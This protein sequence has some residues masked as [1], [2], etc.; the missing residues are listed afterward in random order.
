MQE[1]R[2]WVKVSIHSQAFAEAQ[3]AELHVEVP[4]NYGGNFPLY[5]TKVSLRAGKCQLFL[6]LSFPTC[7]VSE[8][9]LLRGLASTSFASILTSCHSPVRRLK[10]GLYCQ[11]TQAWQLRAPLLWIQILA[12]WW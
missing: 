7:K 10:V 12:S 11:G 3:S 5:L 8:G 9:A 6:R 2:P 4:E 1:D